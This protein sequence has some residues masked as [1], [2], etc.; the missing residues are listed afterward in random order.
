MIWSWG[1]GA[2]SKG[3]GGAMW[4]ASP[5]A[6]PNTHAGRGDRGARPLPISFPL[7]PLY[8]QPQGLRLEAF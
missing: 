1:W 4:R 7:P 5:P 6:S 2:R 8:L 3:R